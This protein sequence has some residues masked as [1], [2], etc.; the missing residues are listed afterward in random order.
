MEGKVRIY[1]PELEQK[2]DL[3]RLRPRVRCV[4]AGA[5]R[6]LG[7]QHRRVSA[8]VVTTIVAVLAFIIVVLASIRIVQPQQ[9][10]VVERLGR[11]RRTLE[12]GIHLL[13]PF[14]E[15]VRAKV[16][17]REQVAS[18]PPQPAITSDNLVACIGTVL[19]YQ[20]ADPVRA[21]YEIGNAV[22]AMEMLTITTLRNLVGS[23][24]LEQARASRDEIN[25]QLAGV[26]NEGTDAWGI[27]VNWTEI[28]AIESGS[29][30]GCT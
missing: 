11:Y 6:G 19:Y 22:Q 21:T 16:N 4:S 25:V 17:M 9:T 10:Y 2:D 12:P 18:F 20:V 29:R 27:K 23:M 24:D 1:S 8:G 14:I 15:S 30:L 13:V 5:A 3:V 26:L 28:K 7:W